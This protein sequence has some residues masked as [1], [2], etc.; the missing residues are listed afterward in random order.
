MARIAEELPHRRFLHDLACIHHHD[1]LRVFG[2]HAHRMRDEQHGHCV[3]FLQAGEQLEDLGLDGYVQCGG[4][5]IRDEEFGIAGK[6]HGDHD[7]LAHAAGKLVWIVVHPACRVGNLHQREHLGRPVDGRAPGKAFVQAQDLGDL[8]ADAVD[9]VERSHRLLEHD[10]DFFAAQLVHFHWTQRDE[11]ASLPKNLSR[12][13][14]S[15]RR[16]DQL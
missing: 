7:A 14:A 16:R 10:A 6:R 15:G 9:R 11:V 2:D 1:S 8:V 12:G 3:L 5:L 13:D 4:W